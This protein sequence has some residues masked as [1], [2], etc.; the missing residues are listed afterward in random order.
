[1]SAR[2]LIS[3]KEK[4][5]LKSKY[6]EKVNEDF[7]FTPDPVP[8]QS[9]QTGQGNLSLLLLHTVSAKQ[10]PLRGQLLLS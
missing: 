10:A 5:I 3:F 1:M 6:V 8:A 2:R 9:I 4:D 7:N